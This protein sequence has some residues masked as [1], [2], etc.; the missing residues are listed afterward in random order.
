MPATL[1]P[2]TVLDSRGR[3]LTTSGTLYR[4]S[5]DDDQKRPSPPN[6][7]GDFSSLLSA[8]T[9]R[10]LVSESRAQAA[11]GFVN[12]LI[13]SKTGYV[14]ASDYA[15]RFTGTDTR[16]GEEATAWLREATA[17]GNIRGN[18]FDWK[19]SWRPAVRNFADAGAFFVLLTS[20]PDTQQPA[21]QF[22]EAHRVGC[23]DLDVGL[24]GENDAFTDTVAADGT[25]RRVRGA[26]RGLPINNGIITNRAGTEVAV[27][28]LGA[29]KDDDQ[30]ISLRDL[31][32]VGAPKAYSESRPWPD[33]APGLLD[34]LA[35]D[36]AQTAALDQQIADA[37]RDLVEESPTGL[38]PR[39]ARRAR[40]PPSSSAAITGSSRPATR[41][42][43]SIPLAPPTS[44]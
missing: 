41:S 7:Y 21:L 12:A 29:T 44:G 31:I 1:V 11:R 16:W 10:Q 25:T 17:I 37:R 22:I 40:P 24:V 33:L 8:H 43:P 6:H 14:S 35:L 18:R 39:P 4:R 19:S 9:Y 26:Y 2:G 38:P 42:P 20:W 5:R 23:R 32:F 30:D 34:F 36:L 13:E 3:P 28:I 27:R 15:P